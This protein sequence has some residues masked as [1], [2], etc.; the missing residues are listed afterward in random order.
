[1][2]M[3]WTFIFIFRLFCPIGSR[4]MRAIE[5]TGHHGVCMKHGRSN[6]VR[7]HDLLDKLVNSN[8]L[9]VR[10]LSVVIESTYTSLHCTVQ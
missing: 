1:M 3:Y 10:P 7:C 5:A 9:S 2:S 6:S 4:A 8:L